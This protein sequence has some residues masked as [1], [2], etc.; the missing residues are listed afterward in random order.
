MTRLGPRYKLRAFTRF[1]WATDAKYIMNE[2][3]DYLY[4]NDPKFRE[5]TR[6]LA[7]DVF[8]EIMPHIIFT[9]LLS[10]K[11]DKV[12]R[13]VLRNYFA[14][15][16]AFFSNRGLCFYSAQPSKNFECIV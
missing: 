13:P 15:Q 11:I 2:R 5:R 14:A 10:N 4:E 1:S 8:P 3:L 16:G 9:L 12:K 6:E 7:D